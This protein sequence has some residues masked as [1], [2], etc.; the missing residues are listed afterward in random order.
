MTEQYEYLVPLAEALR[1]PIFAGQGVYVFD[2][3][4]WVSYYEGADVTPK[5]TFALIKTISPN[6][7]GEPGDTP[8]VFVG[9]HNP[10]P[11]PPQLTET[12]AQYAARLA[13]LAA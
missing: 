1:Y 3:A 2:G 13:A 4:N 8:P 6:F 12:I 7:V 9:E 10:W 5:G 11:P